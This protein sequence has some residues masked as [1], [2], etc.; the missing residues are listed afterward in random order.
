ML[1]H[2]IILLPTPNMKSWWQAVCELTPSGKQNCHCYFP[3]ISVLCFQDYKMSLSTD[4]IPCQSL[5]LSTLEFPPSPLNERSIRILNMNFEV[6]NIF[7]LW[8]SIS[9]ADL[10]R[11]YYHLSSHS[12]PAGLHPFPT[13]RSVSRWDPQDYWGFLGGGVNPVRKAKPWRSAHMSHLWTKILIFCQFYIWNTAIREGNA[14]F[15]HHPFPLMG[16][17]CETCEVA[18]FS[19]W[20]FKS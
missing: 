19:S 6:Q 9:L 3:Q 5:N 17:M 11:R 13:S 7:R 10:E 1:S 4:S 16:G 2:F 18:M 12:E 8:A 14:S 20:I 15:M